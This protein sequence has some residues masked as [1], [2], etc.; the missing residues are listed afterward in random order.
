MAVGG[1]IFS[2]SGTVQFGG[3]AQNLVYKQTVTGTMSNYGGGGW[4]CSTGTITVNARTPVLAFRTGKFAA[5]E[6]VTKIGTD[7][8]LYDFTAEG[9]G[10]D[11]SITAYVFDQSSAV[12][13]TSFPNL[14]VQMFDP[15]AQQSFHSSQKPMIVA[16]INVNPSAKDYPGKTIAA[17]PTGAPWFFWAA[18]PPE[19]LDTS[20][21]YGEY[22]LPACRVSGSTLY[23]QRVI[24]FRGAG[25]FGYTPG[26]RTWTDGGQLL[27]V[28]DVG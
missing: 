25:L 4:Q 18:P 6:T 21:Y 5:I 22:Y 20:A 23:A 17:L 3:D 7:Q 16:D 2:T 19:F 9:W 15:S 8:W 14:G 1:Q 26:P 12:P 24:P 10:G 27:S 11:Q 13:V 28:F